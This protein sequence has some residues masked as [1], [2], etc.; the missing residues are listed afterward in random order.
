M[1]VAPNWG[2]V[3]LL[4]APLKTPHGVRAA[5]RMYAS[6]ISFVR[7]VDAEK[8][9]WMDARRCWGWEDMEDLYAVQI[10]RRKAGDAIL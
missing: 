9:R 6:W 4:K 1:A 2:A 3:T 10:G 8:W 5:E 7:R